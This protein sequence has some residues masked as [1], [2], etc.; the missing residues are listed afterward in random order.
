MFR[1]KRKE[2]IKVEGRNL[3]FHVSMQHGNV[4]KPTFFWGYLV[5]G[6]LDH[7]TKKQNANVMLYQVFY[8]MGSKTSQLRLNY[9][10]C[11]EHPLIHNFVNNFRGIENFGI[12]IKI[13]I[14]KLSDNNNILFMD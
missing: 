3:M 6:L 10:S 4:K 8:P 1:R 13:K 9:T 12:I 2:E 14:T 7:I 5:Q 11:P